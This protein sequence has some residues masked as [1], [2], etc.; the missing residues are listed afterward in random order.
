MS[1]KRKAD[2][3]EVLS[4]E[5]KEEKKEEKKGKHQL[6]GTVIVDYDKKLGEGS[7]GKVCIGH[8]L[9]TTDQ[10]A[11]KFI[12]ADDVEQTEETI[13]ISVDHKN[14]VKTHTIIKKKEGSYFVMEKANSCLADYDFKSTEPE[15]FGLMM[16]DIARGM[17]YL[18]SINVMHLD[19]KPAN[20][21]LFEEN[22]DIVCK[23]ADFSLSHQGAEQVFSHALGTPG[24][25]SPETDKDHKATKYADVYAFGVLMC[26]LAKKMQPTQMMCGFF[27]L[28]QL[29]CDTNVE[30][31]YTF[32]EIYK[33]LEF[34]TASIKR[35]PKLITMSYDI[36]KPCV[37]LIRSQHRRP[38][39]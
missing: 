24:F 22:K 9:L 38:V 3:I 11:V 7:Y 29:C 25:R 16:M 28:A 30:V 2:T 37:D 10:T 12:P 4:D 17:K 18:H 39:V 32:A 13:A 20:I 19:L 36:S 33:Q 23:I 35:M 27:L 1:K 26:Y 31:R 5:D 14:V 15:T 8:G 6:T 21:L 34:H